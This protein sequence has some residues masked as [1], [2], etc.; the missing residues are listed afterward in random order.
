MR[1]SR[2]SSRHRTRQPPSSQG[3]KL[4]TQ[5]AQVQRQAAQRDFRFKEASD[6]NPN[7]WSGEDTN[8][9]FTAFRMELQ[10][11]VGAWHDHM[12]NAVE[13]AEPKEVRITEA[14][15]RNVGMSQDTIGD[16][17]RWTSM[18]CQFLVACTKGKAKNYVCNTEVTDGQRFLFQTWRRQACCVLASDTQRVQ[19]E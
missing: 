10:S 1:E 14:D 2:R 17:K 3:C 6:I 19:V 11:W 7:E 12:L 4:Q 16:L 15:D 8:E 18:L 9:P 13:L 5:G